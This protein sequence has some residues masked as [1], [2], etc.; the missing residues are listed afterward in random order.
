MLRLQIKKAAS[1]IIPKAIVLTQRMTQKITT[2][3]SREIF[4]SKT[5]VSEQVNKV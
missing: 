3:S 1:E 4:F 2:Q 5:L